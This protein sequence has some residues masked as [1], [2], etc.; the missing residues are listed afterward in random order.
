MS[1]SN[2]DTV[3]ITQAQTFHSE[4]S[5]KMLNHSLSLQY[6]QKLNENINF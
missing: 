4:K 6:S 3:S 1:K 5:I 2:K